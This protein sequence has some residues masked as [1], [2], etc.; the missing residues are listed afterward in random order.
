MKIKKL[1]RGSGVEYRWQVGKLD[2]TCDRYYY[3]SEFGIDYHKAIKCL[4]I[5][6]GKLLFCLKVRRILMTEENEPKKRRKQAAQVVK[7][8]AK[9]LEK[10]QESNII[11]SGKGFLKSVGDLLDGSEKKE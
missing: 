4:V 1:S 5:K 2:I 11:E 8:V 9:G 7:K 3:Y 6:C 10:V